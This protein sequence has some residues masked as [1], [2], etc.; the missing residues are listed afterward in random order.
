MSFRDTPIEESGISL[1]FP[2]L[3]YRPPLCNLYDVFRCHL[4]C[5]FHIFYWQVQDAQYHTTIERKNVIN[6][7]DWE[8]RKHPL[9]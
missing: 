6:R 9:Q 3:S 7:W 2:V 8:F 5:A 1:V 4:S